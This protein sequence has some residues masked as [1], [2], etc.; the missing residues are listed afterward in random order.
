MKIRGFL[1]V[2]LLAFAFQL[3]A[4]VT[5]EVTLDQ[6]QFLP[7]ESLTAIVRI[8]NRS[9]Q[10]L[11]LGAE[12]N[13]L[14]FMVES[15]DSFVV[16]KNGEAPVAGEFVLESAQAAIK[17]VDIAPYFNLRKPGRYSVSAMV[18]IKDWN[19]R[20][21]SAAR[22]FDLIR[23]AKIWEQEVGLPR[24]DGTTGPPEV[25]TYAL[26]EANYLK[27]LMLYFQLTDQTGHLNRVYPI[28]P[29]LSFGK[30]E[31]QVDRIS[32]LHVL[33]QNGPRM[34]S[35]LVINPEGDIMSRQSYEYSLPRPRLRTTEDGTLG[36]VG[37]TRRV[38][39][40]DLP[41]PPLPLA[42]E[43]KLPATN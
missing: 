37:G 17:R 21:T 32:N 10:P 23:G 18:T 29:L 31:A 33:Y 12:E 7:G 5:V 20:L 15:L 42:T 27:K 43:S 1:S 14:R 34:F 22:P 38:R 8:T 40:D 19:Q 41:P 4:Q 30:P 9:G 11:R 36:I 2:L 16:V 6:E 39:S 26:Q 24:R 13:W 3:P 35:Y 25:R 28:G